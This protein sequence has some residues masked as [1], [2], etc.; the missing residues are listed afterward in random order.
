MNQ[1]P[2]L[3]IIR[4]SLSRKVYEKN[5]VLYSLPFQ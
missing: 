4:F 2:F 3:I 5:Q 1:A